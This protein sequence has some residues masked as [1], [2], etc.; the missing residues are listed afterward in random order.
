MIA[1]TPKETSDETPKLVI[2]NIKGTIISAG[3]EINIK[4]KSEKENKI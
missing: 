1:I 2:T 4:I 3:N